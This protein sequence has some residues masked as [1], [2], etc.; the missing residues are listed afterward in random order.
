MHS[1]PLL[2]TEARITAASAQDTQTGL[3]GYVTLV[4]NGAL[5]LDGL[6]LRRSAAGVLYLAFPCR[7]DRHGDRHPLV[8][9][10][11]EQA[12]VELEREVFRALRAGGGR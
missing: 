9:P 7:T 3:L 8:R 10:I 5:A 11:S 12:R 6:V 4:L 1:G 2:V